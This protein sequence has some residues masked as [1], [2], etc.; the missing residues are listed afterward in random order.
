MAMEPFWEDSYRRPGAADTFGGGKPSRDVVDLAD[1]LPPGGR[2]LDLGCGDGRNALFLAER[3]FDTTAVDISR[4]GIDKL[5]AVAADRG[6]VVQAHVQDMREY[7]FEG[8]FDLIVSHGCLHFLERESWGVVLGRVQTSTAAGGYNVISVFT[9]VVPAPE[10]LRELMIGLF[11]EGELF[12]LYSGWKSLGHGS[13]IFEDEHPGS[14]KHEH[15]SNW[16]VAQ[17]P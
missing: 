9:D 2:V 13:R 10:D 17:K 8:P 6:V 4:A 15:A 12:G 3:G 11:R 1:K 5:Q 7:A 16:I 14:P